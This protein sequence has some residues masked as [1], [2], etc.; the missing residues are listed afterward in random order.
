LKAGVLNAPDCQAATFLLMTKLFIW[1]CRLMTSLFSRARIGIRQHCSG[2]NG[3][4]EAVIDFAAGAIK[5]Q[6]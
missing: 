2:S 3:I 5:I 6:R 4:N 1:H